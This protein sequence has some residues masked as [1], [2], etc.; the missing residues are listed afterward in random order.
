[1]GLNIGPE[2]VI[3][4]SQTIQSYTSTSDLSIN[5]NISQSLRFINAL[6]VRIVDPPFL[7]C[8]LESSTTLILSSFVVCSNNLQSFVVTTLADALNK[9]SSKTIIIS[10]TSMAFKLPQATQ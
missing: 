1:M 8:Q 7:I 4:T 2:I 3:W 5:E 9:Q 6:I 10:Y